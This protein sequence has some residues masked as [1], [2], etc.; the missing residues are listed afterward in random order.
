MKPSTKRTLADFIHPP[1]LTHF[2]RLTSKDG[3]IQHADL[4]VPDPSFGYSIDDNARALIVCLWHYQQYQDASILRLAEV[5]FNYLKKVE[6]EGGSFHNFLSFTE[7]TLDAEGSEDSIGRAVWALGETIAHHPDEAVRLEAAAMLERTRLQKHIDHAHIRSK[8]Y[9][10]LGLAAAGQRDQVSAWADLLVAA[11]RHEQAP[12][13]Q[14]FEGLLCYANGILPYALLVAHQATGSAE[15]L[16]VARKTLHWLDRVSRIGAT[17]APIGHAGWF[18]R[19]QERAEYDQQPLDAADMALA[20]AKLHEITHDSHDLER[21]LE[22][23]S[24]YD[25]HNTQKKSVINEATK[26]IY[27]AIT[28]GGVNLNQGAESIVTYLLAYLS[29]ARLHHR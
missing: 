5:Y 24:W 18:Y 2:K 20:W 12:D 28:P 13:W 29:L 22:W 26:G 4:E 16:V 17:P 10:L 23:M 15:Y 14:W 3:I 7:K 8:A 25:G 9:I 11:Y 19:G 27:D 1:A 21:A 6:I